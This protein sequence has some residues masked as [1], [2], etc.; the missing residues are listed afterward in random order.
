[1]TIDSFRLNLLPVWMTEIWLESRSH[2]VLVSGQNG[3]TQS[4]IIVKSNKP[5]IKDWLGDLLKD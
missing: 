1:M 2:L 5:N 4:D 3:A